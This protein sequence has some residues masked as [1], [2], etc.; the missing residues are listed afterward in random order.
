MSRGILVL[1]FWG[2][3]PLPYP[4]RSSNLKLKTLFVAPLFRS[5]GE[6]MYL[7]LDLFYNNSNN[8]ALSYVASDSWVDLYGVSGLRTKRAC[9]TGTCSDAYVHTHSTCINYTTLQWLQPASSHSSAG[10]FM[11]LCVW[12]WIACAVFQLVCWPCLGD[13]LMAALLWEQSSL[14]PLLPHSSLDTFS[15]SLSLFLI[16]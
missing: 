8:N 7:Y 1:L 10:I 16:C 15:I 5:T 6:I 2:S 3:L 4:L 11:H 14:C 9:C 13:I 12:A